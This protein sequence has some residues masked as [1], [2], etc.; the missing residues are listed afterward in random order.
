MLLES[1]AADIADR[2]SRLMVAQSEECYLL[3]RLHAR[4]M[5]TTLDRQYLRILLDE[6]R[7]REKR[8]ALQENALHDQLQR[9][10]TSVVERRPALL[11]N[12][13]SLGAFQC[14]LTEVIQ[15][16]YQ[17]FAAD[18]EDGPFVSL[19]C[20][21][22][23]YK[24]SKDMALI[25]QQLFTSRRVLSGPTVLSVLD[26]LFPLGEGPAETLHMGFSL[27]SEVRHELLNMRHALQVLM[28]LWTHAAIR[29]GIATVVHPDTCT[30]AIQ[31]VFAEQR[32][33]VEVMMERVA[34]K[35]AASE[36]AA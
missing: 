16:A 19:P 29:G 6:A 36:Q 9:W 15:Q 8:R 3:Q 30:A 23:L 24:P 11:A 10:E 7:T 12:W 22:Y 2:F 26:N 32:R 17:L 21:A 27:R 25:H 1:E 13:R 28:V 34:Q 14:V 20:C 31:V 5:S 18:L 33:A 4:D 35:V